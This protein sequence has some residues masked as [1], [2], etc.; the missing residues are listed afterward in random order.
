LGLGAENLSEA[1]I[2]FQQA[3]DDVNY[4]LNNRVES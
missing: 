2:V 1:L 4:K 3:I